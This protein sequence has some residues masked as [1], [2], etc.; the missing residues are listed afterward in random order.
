MNIAARS[1]LK[2]ILDV[3]LQT[4][5]VEAV[6]L[7]GS[8]AYGQ[9]DD[10]SDFDIYVVIPD[11]SLRPIEA[12]Q[13]LNCALYGVNHRPVDILVSWASNFAQRIAAPTLEQTVARK[14]VILYDRAS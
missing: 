8:H 13:K 6:Y 7:F 14:G 11:N 4:L 10:E 5:E 12:M 9:P 3:I 2:N 1:Q